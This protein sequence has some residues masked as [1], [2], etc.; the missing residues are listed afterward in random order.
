[1][2]DLEM[3]EM[4]TG[5]TGTTLK[6]IAIVAMFIDHFAAIFVE[7]YIMSVTPASFSSAEAQMAWFRENPGVAIME[8]V[9]V[10]M[11]L[12]GRFGFPLFAFLIVE[13]F[14]HTRSVKNM[15]LTLACSH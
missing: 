11:R 9:Y 8:I 7:H 5:V 15:H 4:K 2:A 3:T 14:Q 10:V 1:M 12:I 13:G 6:I